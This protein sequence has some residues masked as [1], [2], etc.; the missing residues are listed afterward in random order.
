MNFHRKP[1]NF[2]RFLDIRNAKTMWLE[3]SNLIIGAEADLVLAQAFKTL[4]PVREPA[5]RIQWPLTICTSFTTE[6]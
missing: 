6:K 5:S 4:E 2:I 3:L 1:V